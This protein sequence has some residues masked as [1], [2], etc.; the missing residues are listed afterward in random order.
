M[1]KFLFGTESSELTACVQTNRDDVVG[2]EYFVSKNTTTMK[3]NL[4]IMGTENKMQKVRETVAAGALPNCLCN[5]IYFSRNITATLSRHEH[6]FIT[7]GILDVA[8][9]TGEFRPPARS[10][11]IPAVRQ[12]EMDV[13]N[14]PFYI[15][16]GTI[17]KVYRKGA[18]KGEGL[19]YEDAWRQ[20]NLLKALN[21]G[22]NSP[23]LYLEPKDEPMDVFQ[24]QAFACDFDNADDRY[25]PCAFLL[26]SSIPRDELEKTMNRPHTDDIHEGGF[27]G[28]ALTPMPKGQETIFGSMM[29]RSGIIIL[30]VLQPIDKDRLAD[31]KRHID[32][33]R[34]RWVAKNVF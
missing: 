3:G 14:G 21:Y 12:G 5:D 31:W 34:M 2:S 7:K 9:A 25:C 17:V 28:W 32:D 29:H 30:R 13:V 24:Y 4:Y 16:Y 22:I 6:G 23:M 19:R 15:G 11:P 18:D 27:M 8:E 10:I 20:P 26:T 33:T 1:Q